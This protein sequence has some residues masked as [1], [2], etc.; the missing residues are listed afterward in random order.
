MAHTPES[1]AKML[2]TRRA[3]REARGGAPLRK[4]SAASKKRMLAK[5]HN[6]AS[7]RKAARTRRRNYLLRKAGHSTAL[8][9][10]SLGAAAVAPENLPVIING[11]KSDVQEF[12]AF[13]AEAWKIYKGQ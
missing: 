2:A 11:E 6:R 9:R 13:M 1:I 7:R 10:A 4:I 3:N 12:A 5:L 8:P